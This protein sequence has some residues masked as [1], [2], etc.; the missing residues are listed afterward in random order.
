MKK[1]AIKEKSD[2]PSIDI[3]EGAERILESEACKNQAFIY[4]ENV[5]A[6]QCHFEMSE[7]SIDSIVDKV[8][9]QLIKN[10][11][12]QSADEI[13]ARK[14]LIHLNEKVLFEILDRIENIQ[15]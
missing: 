15:E 4:N 3:P 11:Y 7:E 10:K 14:N 1:L 8:G 6:F 9:H 12:V 13:L 5:Y 2:L